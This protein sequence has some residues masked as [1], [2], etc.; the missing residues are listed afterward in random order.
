MNNFQR[1]GK[2]KK[3]LETLKAWC[4][5]QTPTLNFSVSN[6]VVG[7]RKEKWF[8]R[9]W[10]LSKTVEIFEAEHD[11]RIYQLGQRLYPGN[12]A[13]LF[14][15]YPTGAYIKPHRD[16]TTSEA[17]VVQINIGCPVT[18]TVGEEQHEVLDGEVIKFN[19][20]LLHSTSP[21]TADRWVISWRKI[22]SQY[23]NQQ[24]DLFATGE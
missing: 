21:A 5:K 24:L 14:L 16:H 15:Y 18:L 13:C 4:Q 1:I 23:L 19:S 11:E 8:E 20:K 9:G 22:K 3:D 6:Y 12:H 7:G 10:T 17:E 2:V